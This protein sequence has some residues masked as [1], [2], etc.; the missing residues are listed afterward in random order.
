MKTQKNRC[1]FASAALLAAALSASAIPAYPASSSSL[2]IDD[3]SSGYFPGQGVVINRAAG[4]S[5]R[6]GRQVELS[7]HFE[8]TPSQ[9]DVRCDY[10]DGDA[11]GSPGQVALDWTPLAG[12]RISA[13][14]VWR[15]SVNLPLSLDWIV[16][17]V[18][19]HSTK[20]ESNPQKVKWGIGINWLL[21]GQSNI[22]RAWHDGESRRIQASSRTASFTRSGW[23]RVDATLPSWDSCCGAN[24]NAKAF[25]NSLSDACNCLVGLMPFTNAGTRI[26]QWLSPAN[27]GPGSG[28]NTWDKFLNLKGDAVPIKVE[29]I[30]NSSPA[31]VHAPG[32]HISNGEVVTFLDI[33]GMTQ[34]NA[35]DFVA[36]NVNGDDFQ[37]LDR[38]GIPVDSSSYAAFE[39]GGVV[40][41]KAGIG[42]P[43]LFEHD[44]EGAIWQQGENNGG[45]IEANYYSLLETLW[46]QLASASG[47]S[48]KD[49]AFG[50]VL[51]GTY[52]PTN[53]S[54]PVPVDFH[55]G[56]RQAELRFIDRHKGSTRAFF[57]GSLLTA[58]HDPTDHS[59]ADAGH[60]NFSDYV[61]LFRQLIQSSLKEIGLAT[62]GADGPVIS[63]AI[64]PL[65]SDE[66]V[67]TVAHDGGQRLQDYLGSTAPPQISGFRVFRNGKQCSILKAWFD[68]PSS[69]RLKTDCVRMSSDAVLLDYGYGANPGDLKYLAWASLAAAQRSTTIT[70]ARAQKLF[71]AA[72][73]GNTIVISGGDN[74]VPGNYAVVRVIDP[75]NAVLDKSPA[76]DGP[77]ANGQA[78][79]I[80]SQTHLVY[81]DFT[82][83]KGTRYPDSVGT[84]LEPTRGFVQVA[85]N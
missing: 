44:Y 74:F 85:P 2:T 36:G 22:G 12:L 78:S 15:G 41:A 64:M 59:G 50:V 55:E 67:V 63:H 57:A 31:V 48:D 1:F 77:G 53:A 9:V 38:N 23:H 72:I 84:P 49:F 58:T 40:I 60:A 66:V 51:L 18:R 30:S 14:S 47:R 69:V 76:P 43:L 70:D 62:H 75:N 25:A 5:A 65:S 3:F 16:C 34:L 39:P 24:D 28:E 71:A 52:V 21:I 79:L 19:D 80:H 4:A 8:S 56:V 61:H 32:H 11:V 17:S 26:Q 33:G 46:R 45:A 37:L 29:A 54:G 7:G 82:P 73:P 68:E 83:A 81:D 10:A 6:A 35:K 13:N 42:A 27:G 20:K